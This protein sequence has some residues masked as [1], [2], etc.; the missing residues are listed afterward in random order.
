MTA[1]FAAYVAPDGNLYMQEGAV[2]CLAGTTTHFT[3]GGGLG[4]PFSPVAEP[5]GPAVAAGTGGA[6]YGGAGN[7]VQAPSP[8]LATIVPD[9]FFK[10]AGPDEWTA[11]TLTMTFDPGTGA[12]D[13]DDGVDVLAS[14]PGG[15]ATFAPYGTF[16]STTYGETT[17]N[18]GTPFSIVA[19]Y[20]GGPVYPTRDCIVSASGSTA[21]EGRYARTGWQSW[22][23]L[24]DPAWTLTID[25][26]GAGVISDGTDDVL[27]R[28]ADAGALYDPAG[29]WEATTYGETT[30]GGGEFFYGGAAL[31][32]TRPIAGY[33][34]VTLELD[35]NDEVTGVTGPFFAP[36]LPANSATEVSVPIAYSNGT[37]T[38]SQIQLG[39]IIWRPNP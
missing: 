24:D 9:G 11:G 13:I 32:A 26:T 28:A 20:E 14:L 6:F 35:A 21:Q 12:A 22:E 15:S 25:G 31:L 39:P 5:I 30:Y 33:L 38:V 37:G 2:I 8:V 16:S 36:S 10:P 4:V 27:T 17:Y 7:N 1:P 19:D 23:S 18:G 34:F 3:V 29:T